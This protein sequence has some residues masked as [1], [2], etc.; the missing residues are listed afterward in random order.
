M[1]T[2][3]HQIVKNH[4]EHASTIAKRQEIISRLNDAQLKLSAQIKNGPERHRLIIEKDELVSELREINKDIRQNGANVASF[5]MEV[6]TESLP[7]SVRHLVL[8]EA[9]RRQKGEPPKRVSLY[10]EEEQNALDYHVQLD[11]QYKELRK[12]VFEIKKWID[13]KMPN[14]KGSLNQNEYMVRAQITKAY[15]KIL[16][17]LNDKQS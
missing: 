15:S 8:H 12:K 5:F 6:V 2:P 10:T 9:D 17:I 3:L 13:E 4:P 14:L 1:G 7:D 16:Q 11:R